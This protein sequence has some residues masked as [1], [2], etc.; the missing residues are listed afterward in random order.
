MTLYVPYT[1]VREGTDIFLR[2]FHPDA[3]LVD[4]RGDKG[5]YHRH[6]SDRWKE[7]KTFVNMEHDVIPWPGAVESLLVCPS[8]WCVFA[9]A[10]FDV[11]GT[12]PNLLLAKFT[13]GFISRLPHCWDDMDAKIGG[14]KWD[15]C[16]IWVSLYA[17]ERGVLP[18]QHV[19]G[20]LN[21]NPRYL[22]LEMGRSAL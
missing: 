21:A 5:A 20:I 14:D 12:G 17:R 6:L 9:D 13:E 11:L 2:R 10:N 3:V 15:N 22:N 8:P 18:H 1:H 19:P 7:G 16:D 4:C